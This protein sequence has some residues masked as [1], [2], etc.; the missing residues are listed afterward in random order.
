MPSV[1]DILFWVAFAAILFLTRR[2]RIFWPLLALGL[3]N[4]TPS[5]R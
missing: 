2:Q 1:P 3:P 5:S 4:S